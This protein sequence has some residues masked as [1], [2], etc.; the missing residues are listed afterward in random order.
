V[1]AFPLDQL[2]VAFE[3]YQGTS[4]E[5][6]SFLARGPGYG[7]LL[8]PTR[9]SLALQSPSAKGT[10]AGHR[11]SDRD[12]FTIG[13]VGASAKGSIQGIDDL[14]GKTNYIFGNDPA[15]WR[16]GVSTF[17]KVKYESIYSGIDLIFYGT[18][19]QLEYDLVVHPGANPDDV[20]FSIAGSGIATLEDDGALRLNARKGDI[21]FKAPLIYQDLPAG[22]KNIDGHFRLVRERTG[23]QRL[24][25]VVGSYDHSRE[26]IIDPVVDYSTYLGGVANDYAA[27]VAVDGQGN[28][29]LTGG[30]ASLDFPVTPDAVFPVLD[31]C[32]VGCSDA[33]VAK[34]ST[35][36]NGLVYATYLGGSNADA[37]TSIAV[38]SVGNAYIAGLTN[39]TDFPTTS[40]A[41]QR[42]C[43]GTCF[44]NDAFVVKLNSTGSALLYS[45]YLGGSNEDFATSIA[46]RGNNAYIGGFSG[47][48]DF[49]VTQ[50]AFQTSAQGQGSSFVVKLN[51]TGTGLV[52]GTFLGEVDLQDAGGYIALDSVG[53]IYVTGNTL[54]SNFPV[55]TGAFHTPFL[56]PLA[57]NM[58]VL[59][60]DPTG[61]SL[62]YSALIGGATPYGI[63]VDSTG[64]AYV[65]GSAGPSAPVSPGAIDQSCDSGFLVLKLN[66][67]GSN[68][69][70]SAHLCPDRVWPTGVTVD[71][72]R[73]II[74]SA[75]TDST[76]LPTTTGSF[77]AI[78]PSECCFS[79]G[80]LGKLTPDG[81][82]LAY[83]T[84]F[85][86]NGPDSLNA[87]AK[88]ASQN[89]YLAGST[90]STNF[91]L[92]GGFQT[93]NAGF[94]DAF[95]AKVTLPNLRVSIS[96]AALTFPAWGVGSETQPVAVTFANLSTANVAFSS[97]VA[98]PNFTVSGN[99]C[100]SEVLPGTHC[101][102]LVTFAPTLAGN[103]SGLLTITDGAGIH[104]VKLAGTAVS[105]PFVA[106]SGSSLI[107]TA[108]GV[109]SPPSPIT[110]TNVGT[111]PLTIT[112]FGLSNAP[113]F[114]FG[115][116]GTCF[117]TI[118][119]GGSC[120]MTITLTGEFGGGQTSATLTL[121]DN[122][123]N[124]PQSFF[125]TGNISGSGLAF[126]APSVRF[127]QQSVGTSSPVQRIA[128]LNATGADVTFSAFKATA[129][130][131]QSH[132]CGSTLKAGAFCYVNVIFKPLSKGIKQGTVS[133][134]SSASA[135]PLTLP[136]LGTGD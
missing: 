69:L 28:A 80:V 107:G 114:N 54:S 24:S 93:A 8:S 65:A 7:L 126:G 103:R 86:G 3:R 33:F 76:D 84:Y 20:A 77:I 48:P 95:L 133:V 26:L 100:S 62:T 122:A 136:L 45:T 22:R 43:G 120:T 81:S 27:G 101:Q 123:K 90:N 42:S 34:I 92:Q 1:A 116:V 63:A 15:K 79:T 31:T 6:Q 99:N 12:V 29:Y 50:G 38:D 57:S 130:F 37:G 131:G 53:N 49:P 41:L 5:V 135:T 106:F 66:P 23:E 127:T 73:N 105:G 118:A 87:I 2:P 117:N 10:S 52:F 70:T 17:R 83:L 91:P 14:P 25:F 72:Q 121:T 64:S 30:T 88:D 82:S 36:G 74:F 112:D 55:T 128:L 16:I 39:S 51:P 58:Y 134:T 11:W 94:S 46:V 21:R 71:A 19:R 132:T 67:S 59:K 110:I 109:T 78:K 32:T 9:I 119:P 61:T 47:S 56:P 18:G 102:I 98:S 68:L 115:S 85:G 125:L 75:Y 129:N 89:L 35:T 4:P 96:P 44:N 104:H 111:Q 60:L 13:F 108:L 40:K 113:E 97:V 124:S